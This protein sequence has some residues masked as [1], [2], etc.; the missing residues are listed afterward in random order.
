[1]RSRFKTI[2]AR[3]MVFANEEEFQNYLSQIEAS[4]GTVL[5]VNA[6]RYVSANFSSNLPFPEGVLTNQGRIMSSSG[7]VRVGSRVLS[8]DEISNLNSLDL[9]IPNA[10]IYSVW[11]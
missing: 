7:E 10:D 11:R 5:K 8:A 9:K 4:G 2:T 1:M 3:V 6:L